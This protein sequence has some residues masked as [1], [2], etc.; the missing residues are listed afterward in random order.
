MPNIKGI[1]ANSLHLCNRFCAKSLSISKK[2]FRAG[3]LGK[4]L[5]KIWVYF[6]AGLCYTMDAECRVGSPDLVKWAPGGRIFR[7]KFILRRRFS[8]EQAIQGRNRGWR[9]LVCVVLFQN[10]THYRKEYCKHWQK[11]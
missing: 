1:I 3:S 4:I 7:L 10:S 2:K 11:N 8:T 6:C 9:L 5:L